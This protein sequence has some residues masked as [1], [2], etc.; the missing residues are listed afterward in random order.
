M[1]HHTT[2]AV[3]TAI[4]VLLFTLTAVAG[5]PLSINYQARLADNQGDP[6]PDSSY[7]MEFRFY[8]DS[9]SGTPE[10]TRVMDV[11]THNG[12]FNAAIGE[13]DSLDLEAFGQRTF[14]EVAIGGETVS[15]RMPMNHVPYS[16]VSQRVLGDIQTGIGLLRLMEPL[17]SFPA[18]EMT[19]DGIQNEFKINWMEPLDYPP[20]AFDF[21][22]N[23]EGGIFQMV[24]M[25]PLDCPAVKISAGN[26]GGISNVAS[27]VMFN[28]QPE[29]PAQP[30]LEMKTM[31]LGASFAMASPQTGGPGDDITD[32]ALL[33][34]ADSTGGGIE[35]SDA[36]G[37]CWGTEPSPFTPGAIMY[38]ID[39]S[40]EDTNMTLG[41]DGTL[42]ALKGDFGFNNFDSGE[43]NLSVG[44]YNNLTGSYSFG[45][46]YLA[47]VF[48]NNCFVWSDYVP[49]TGLPTTS[50][51]QFLVRAT[52]GAIFYT[53]STMNTG[54]SLSPGSSSWNSII[55]TF[56]ADNSGDLDGSDILGKIERLSI[57]RY[58]ADSEVHHVSPSPEEFNGLFN[59]GSANDQICPQDQ[60]AIA[61]AGMQEM[62]NIINELRAKNAELES[63]IAELES[64]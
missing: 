8:A 57:K 58:A 56:T 43:N 17:D 19:A 48:H 7:S 2:I 60:S 35:L 1:Q 34:Y 39:P 51:N 22:A 33:I 30:L 28:P 46:G 26:G 50:N 27:M 40:V 59:V 62:M 45:G 31:E 52:G 16:A 47:Q 21:K 64:R 49:D 9:T 44:A 53:N 10:M 5:L 3:W 23:S 24:F 55:P 15:P 25:E 38:F 41:S 18:A 13:G 4:V 14:F 36:I 61:L 32:P 37:K 29:P 20:P 6:V 63:R 12:Y 54:V 11:N 42:K